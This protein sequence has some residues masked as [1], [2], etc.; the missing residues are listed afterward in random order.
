MHSDHFPILALA[1]NS[2]FLERCEIGSNAHDDT[3]RLLLEMSRNPRFG[4]FILLAQITF[5]ASRKHICC[6]RPRVVRARIG[7]WYIVV[8]MEHYVIEEIKLRERAATIS[9][10]KLPVP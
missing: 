5:R 9:T 2:L 3:Y 7:Q 8:E 1:D 4:I 6:D 10:S